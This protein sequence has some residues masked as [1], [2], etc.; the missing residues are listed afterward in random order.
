MQTALMTTGYGGFRLEAWIEENIQD[1][2]ASQE[3]DAVSWTALPYWAEDP[4]LIEMAFLLRIV[5]D[6]GKAAVV[7]HDVVAIE[8][9]I[10]KAKRAL[11]E[12]Q[13]EFGDEME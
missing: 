9:D 4:R 1:L 5:F 7:H 6:L 10:Q 3:Y 8:H 11:Q 13:E 2:V 12:I